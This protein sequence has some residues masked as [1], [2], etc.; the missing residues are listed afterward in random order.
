M[1]HAQG[2][3]DMETS[4]WSRSV[5][6]SNRVSVAR[7]AGAEARAGDDDLQL[8]QWH[9]SNLGNLTYLAI[10]A[11]VSLVTLLAFVPVWLLLQA[12]RAAEQFGTF[13]ARLRPQ[14]GPRG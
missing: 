5:R 10:F 4:T 1:R 3:Q 7:Q 12:Q 9:E 14:S 13:F 11:L 6:L 2:E 8:E